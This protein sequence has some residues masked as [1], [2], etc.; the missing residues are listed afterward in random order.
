MEIGVSIGLVNGLTSI[1]GGAGGFAV[2]RIV[3]AG[4]SI[5]STTENQAG[6][7]ADFYSYTWG[8]SSGKTVSV[9]A[10]ASRTVGGA[11]VGAE[12]ADGGT[13]A[14]NTLF[15]H[16]ADQIAFAPD[17]IHV[18]TGMNDMQ[19]FS[20]NAYRTRL[21]TWASSVRTSGRKII[22]SP[23]TPM[24]A[25]A[26]QNANYAVYT[27]RRTTHM[28]DVRDP[29]VWGQWADYYSPLGEIPDFNT[30]SAV[31]I[32]NG[33]GDGIHPTGPATTGGTG[34]A[35]LLASF[36]Q[37]MASIID[38]T[39]ASS[40]T[41][42]S[43]AWPSS[44]TGLAVSTAI[45]R[46]I[47]VSGIA[48]TGL[49]L[50]AS[51]SGGSATIS[52]N[53][54]TAGTVVGTTIGNGYRI[55]NGD[56]IDLALTTSA[57]GSTAV[58]VDL[59]IGSETRT[60][61]YT[62]SAVVT[63]VALSNAATASIGA[64]STAISLSSLTFGNGAAVVAIT[65]FSTA[66]GTVD[67]VPTSLTLTPTGGG[68]GITLTKQVS[69]GRVASRAFAV[70][71]GTVAAGTY[72]L[73]GT[74][75]NAARC[76]WA[77]YCT[78]ENAD[79]T[80]VAAPAITAPASESDPHLATSVTVP[81]FGLAMGWLMKENTTAGSAGSGS[82]LVNTGD[83]TDTGSTAGLVAVQRSSTGQCAMNTGFGT[84]GRGALAFKALGT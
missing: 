45:T 11:Q 70:Y 48:H 28:A 10:Q 6:F 84:W 30:N 51:V 52:L 46:R 77:S 14:G 42:Y 44:E 20:V 83:V 81:A 65:C 66:G 31:L 26:T 33:P 49:S 4:D 54:G 59:T 47:I 64:S 3:I 27:G 29:A 17:L 38:Q 75:P 40:T 8:D 5:T 53:G 23:P 74:R 73:T 67:S 13:P 34:Q 60:I 43:A 72:N 41:M 25:A 79:P 80:P 15:A 32:N 18:K 39:R 58:N 2:N 21:I 37:I 16:I 7:H 71:T 50:G 19:T 12:L 69:G 68:G 1:S 22:Y 24:R 78:L 62:T 57:S 35:L 76:T 63:P 55:Y 61:S 36:Q 82:T 9:M 56:I